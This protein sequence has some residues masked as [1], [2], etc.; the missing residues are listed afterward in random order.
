MENK[1]DIKRIKAG[2]GIFNFDGNIVTKIIGGWETKGIKCSTPEEVLKV[3]EFGYKSIE[4]GIE[5]GKTITVKAN[6]GSNVAISDVGG[7]IG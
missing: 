6:T 2:K 5:R 7:R 4:K 1:Q 3:L